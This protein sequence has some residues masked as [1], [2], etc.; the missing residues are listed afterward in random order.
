MIA[1]NLSSM[2]FKNVL[3]VLP[4][5]TLLKL[6]EC[7]MWPQFSLRVWFCLRVEP[8]ASKRKIWCGS[9]HVVLQRYS[10]VIFPS[11]NATIR[12]SCHQQSGTKV[13]DHFVGFISYFTA[14]HFQC[15]STSYRHGLYYD[16]QHW[17]RVGRG[18]L[19]WDKQWRNFIWGCQW[20]RDGW[21]PHWLRN[22]CAK[23]QK[24]EARSAC[25]PCGVGSRDPLKGTGGVQ[26]QS[27][28]G[29]PGGEA[30]GSSCVFQCRDNIFNANFL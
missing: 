12:I 29:G 24:N 16:V 4:I 15:W 19:F 6:R 5:Y 13:F 23:V 11:R 3:F 10:C 1:G 20:A 14:L 18:I 2:F 26:G 25:G 17:D 28:C 9:K 27:L 7:D 22:A 30:P 21:V 8:E